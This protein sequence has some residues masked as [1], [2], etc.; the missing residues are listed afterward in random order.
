M[1]VMVGYS[2]PRYAD[3]LPAPP[4]TSLGQM[5]A[6]DLFS[7]I[8][9]AL[10][11]QPVGGT[12]TP[13]ASRT[14]DLEWEEI[15]APDTNVRAYTLSDAQI[16]AVPEVTFGSPLPFVVIV[17]KRQLTTEDVRKLWEGTAYE[18]YE[19]QA[20]YLQEDAAP[21]PTIY[22]FHWGERLDM[23]KLPA[24]TLSIAPRAQAVDGQLVFAMQIPAQGS[25]TRPPPAASFDQALAVKQ[26]QAAPPPAPPPGPPQP[27]Q[28]RPSGTTTSDETSP[29]A[30]PLALGVGAAVLS[31][32]L[33]QKKKR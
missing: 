7:E 22:F 2:E 23:S 15:H 10:G 1:S 6:L 28:I 27:I 17:T 12:F 31:F 33:W 4:G 21:V 20:M 13:W 29:Y 14:G 8:V 32:L 26:A 24:Q 11:L 5:S 30:L 18:P 3:G 25:T 9:T 16:A 19:T